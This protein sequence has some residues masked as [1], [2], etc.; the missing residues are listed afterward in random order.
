MATSGTHARSLFLSGDSEGTGKKFT[1]ARSAALECISMKSFGS[2]YR[3]RD[4]LCCDVAR[5]WGWKAT[6]MQ[7]AMM[8]RCSRGGPIV[9]SVHRAGHIRLDR[10]TP[11]CFPVLPLA[12]S[13]AIPKKIHLGSASR[14]INGPLEPWYLS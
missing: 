2:N 7:R 3:I 12:L 10:A 13:C 1:D 11:S 5:L 14:K 6:V 8:E 9:Q 4:E